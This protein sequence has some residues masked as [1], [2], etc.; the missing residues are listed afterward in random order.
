MYINTYIQLQQIK[1]KEKIIFLSL[2]V[3]EYTL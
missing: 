2:F 1:K 3:M